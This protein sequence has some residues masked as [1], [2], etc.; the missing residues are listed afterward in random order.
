MSPLARG[1]LHKCENCGLPTRRPAYVTEESHL[2]KLRGKT[3]CQTC[4][5]N[6]GKRE[7]RRLMNEDK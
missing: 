2:E 7:M 3:V 5:Q 6:E 4:I 1:G